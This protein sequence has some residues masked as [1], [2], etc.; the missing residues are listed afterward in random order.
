MVFPE[1][2]NLFRDLLSRNR[3]PGYGVSVIDATADHSTIIVELR[4]LAGQDYC[5]AEG[6]CHVPRSNERLVRLA[7]E[8]SIH[9]PDSVVVR[10]RCRVE[11]GARLQCMKSFGLPTESDGYEF[12]ATYG[13]RRDK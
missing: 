13:G 2:D 5:C 6:S 7:A 3:G 12:E 4:F 10:W 11:K 9:L 8:R 1:L